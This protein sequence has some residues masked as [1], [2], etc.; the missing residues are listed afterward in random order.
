MTWTKVYKVDF[1]WS[2]PQAISA[3]P[4]DL[5]LLEVRYHGGTV[6][7]MLD[8]TVSHVV[9]DERWASIRVCGLHISSDQSSLPLQRPQPSVCAA[10]PGARPCQEAPLC[11]QCVGGG[12]S[13]RA[14]PAEREEL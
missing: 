4:L 13:E 6:L 12:L 14:G 9:V 10:L 7:E 3:C 5:T 1:L 11:D 8:E 2:H